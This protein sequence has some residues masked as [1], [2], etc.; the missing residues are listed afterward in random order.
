MSKAQLKHGVQMVTGV[1]AIFIIY[2]ATFTSTYLLV[3]RAIDG[4]QVNANAETTQ[5]VQKS[6]D[7]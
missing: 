7:F 2:V 6:E 1:T 5:S 3:G 4:T